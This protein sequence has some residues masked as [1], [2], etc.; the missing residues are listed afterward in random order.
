ML[1][2]AEVLREVEMLSGLR[3]YPQEEGGVLALAAEFRGCYFDVADLKKAVADFSHDSPFCPTPADVYRV[4][5]STHVRA[6]EG[7]GRCD[8]P[9][10]VSW[11][12]DKGRGWSRRCECR[13]KEAIHA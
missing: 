8:P 10:W 4:W 1:A 5:S 9:G 6:M 11:D 7:C 2:E 12:D 13:T 3:G